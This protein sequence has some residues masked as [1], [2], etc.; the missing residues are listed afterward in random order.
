MGFVKLEPASGK[1]SG[2]NSNMPLLVI[3]SAITNVGTLTTAEANS[4]R[5]YSDEA[6]T[7]ELAREVV[8]ANEIHVK[9]SSV[10]STTDIWMDWDGVRSDYAVGDTYGRNAVWSDYAAVMHLTSN[11]TDATGNLS[12][13]ASS[14]TYDTTARIGTSGIFTSSSSSSVS[15]GNPASFVGMSGLTIQC[16]IRPTTFT[17]F[18]MISAKGDARSWEFRN[19]GTTGKVMFSAQTG[20]FLQSINNCESSVLSTNTWYLVHGRFDGSV[21]PTIDRTR[22]FVN[23]AVDSTNIFNGTSQNTTIASSTDTAFLGRRGD[24]FFWNGRIDEWRLR[25]AALSNDWIATEYQNQN[26]NG[27]FWVA[28]PVGGGYRF[29]PQIR[30]FAGL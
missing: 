28:T 23:G 2:T 20:T 27:A 30:P 22:M 1:V 16:W 29:V 14:L 4:V 24:G 21:S 11:V 17:N 13:T 25:A 10:T 6:K 26:D 5:F 7:V 3:P 8:G 12:P 15:F 19:V 9:V 18:G